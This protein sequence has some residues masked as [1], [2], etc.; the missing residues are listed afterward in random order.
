[1]VNSQHVVILYSSFVAIK[2]YV[3]LFSGIVA[4]AWRTAGT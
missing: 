2:L 1:M 3:A 4:L